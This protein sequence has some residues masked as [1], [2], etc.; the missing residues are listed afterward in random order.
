[1]NG[2]PGP[3][4]MALSDQLW[5]RLERHRRKV[6]LL[7]DMLVKFLRDEPGATNAQFAAFEAMTAKEIGL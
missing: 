5:L 3:S 4:K 7:G 1:M 2:S 6:D